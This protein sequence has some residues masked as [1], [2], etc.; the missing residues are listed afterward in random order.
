[1]V[2]DFFFPN[3]GGVES[4]LYCVSQALIAR[5]HKVVIITHQYD[6]DRVGVRYLTNGLKVY[7]LPHIVI[8]QQATLPTVY[9]LFPLMRQI[10]IREQIQIVHAHQA[11]S[12]IAH[13]AILHARTMSLKAVFT[14]HSLFGFSD[15]SSILTNKL[16]KFSLSDIDHVICVSHTSKENTVLRAALNPHIVSVIPNAVVSSQF[17]PPTASELQ[18][19]RE[20]GVIRS[21]YQKLGR[22]D[23]N[24]DRTAPD[25]IKADLNIKNGGDYGDFD[26]EKAGDK[27]GATQEDHIT[28]VIVSRLT[29]RKGIDL[30]CAVIPMVCE[31][32]FRIRF[33]IAG[34]GPKRIN[35]E[36][37]REKYQLQDRV[38]LLGAIKHTMVR[39]VLVRGQIFLNTS[40]TEAFCIGIIE[41]ASCG[42][43]VV[44]TR[45]GGIVEVLPRSMIM[46]GNDDT[47]M[48]D[49]LMTAV[50]LVRTEGIDRWHFHREIQKMYSWMDVAER[51]ERVYSSILEMPDV[52]LIER[53][54]R[55]YGCGMWA[56]KLFCCIVALNYIFLLF[57]EWLYPRSDI[58]LVPKFDLAEYKERTKYFTSKSIS[59]SQSIK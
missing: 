16:L 56:G 13:E 46:F 3:Y 39:D 23:N 53:L 27:D 58:D 36:Q 15:T 6:E 24:L 25:D 44:S 8:Y 48:V 19:I 43:L 28:I 21:L 17:T 57:L 34:D 5:G 51:T 52:P 32:D 54:R 14:D 40:L 37:M 55:F 22:S 29:Y 9:G 59:N 7:Y 1:M 10:F 50:D 20:H 2:S 33:I 31:L 47:E 12:T 4:H 18:D 30:L 11:F 42:L 49:V 45:V 38:E 41:A 35:L 26:Q